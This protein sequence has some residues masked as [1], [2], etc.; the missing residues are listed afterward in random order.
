M[1]YT[2][3]VKTEICSERDVNDCQTEGAEKCWEI[4]PAVVAGEETV[5]DD[6]SFLRALGKFTTNYYNLFSVH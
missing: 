6:Q 3:L 1:I 4:T 5:L 2:N